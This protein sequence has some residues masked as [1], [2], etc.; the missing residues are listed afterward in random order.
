MAAA[1]LPSGVLGSKCVSL[2][3][4]ESGERRSGDGNAD[5]H[6]EGIVV[7]ANDV[8]VH[9]AGKGGD[10]SSAAAIASA[11]AIA[12][13]AVAVPRTDVD[14]AAASAGGEAAAAAA[15][16]SG[17]GGTASRR[18]ASPPKKQRLISSY[19]FKTHDDNGSLVTTRFPGPHFAPDPVDPTPMCPGCKK[20]FKSPEGM[21]GHGPFCALYQ[22]LK[23]RGRTSAA[24]TP[25]SSSSSSSSRSA[26]TVARAQTKGLP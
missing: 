23:D 19:M 16:T 18:S 11:V 21:V 20:T 10:V 5:V 6:G 24:A 9:V 17:G 1:P 3:N 14:G 12:A 15:V 8:H 2:A 26:A 25:S 4:K 7:D 22:A 13:A